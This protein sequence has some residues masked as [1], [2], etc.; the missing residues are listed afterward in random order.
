MT[1][2][3]YQKECGSCFAFTAIA[4]IESAYIIKGKYLNLAE[5][6]IIDCSDDFG[7]RGCQG[8]WTGNAFKYIASQG[9]VY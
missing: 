1:S 8:G 6:E 5:Q 3:K 7:N 2:V 4:V 9:I